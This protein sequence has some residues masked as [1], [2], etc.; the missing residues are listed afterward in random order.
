MSLWRGELSALPSS[1]AGRVMVCVCGT[2]SDHPNAMRQEAAGK[3]STRQDPPGKGIVVRSEN[4]PLGFCIR[5][6]EYDPTYESPSLRRMALTVLCVA[7]R[8]SR[9]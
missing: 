7:L 1:L 8:Y 6:G 9:W 3:V 4:G 5:Y 2:T